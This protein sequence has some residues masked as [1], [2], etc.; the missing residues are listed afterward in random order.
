MRDEIANMLVQ[1]GCYVNAK[2]T[3]S[4][5]I[6]IPNGDKLI[7][8]LSCRLIISNV[9]IR[10]KIEKELSKR[11]EETFSDDITIVGMAT[12][13]ITWAHAIASKL[14]LP[15]LYVRGNEKSYGLK[16]LIEGNL[17]FANKKVII[18][19]DIL[20]TGDTISKAKNVLK[21]YGMEVVGV[22]CIATL[23]D[24]TVLELKSNRIK[25]ID[26]TNYRNILDSAIKNKVL[27]KEEYNYMKKIYEGDTNNEKSYNS[28]NK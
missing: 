17:K 28:N 4:K 16:G 10:E 18:V 2:N 24:R 13:G 3:G 7:A 19:D 11:V 20:N 26:L 22:V 21:K 5:I 9:E 27:N 23:K 8:Y 15:L 1:T 12:A 25:V 14:R 6:K